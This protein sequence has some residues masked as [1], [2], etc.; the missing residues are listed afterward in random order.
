MNKLH[1]LTGRAGSGKSIKIFNEIAD[2]MDKGGDIWRVLLV[3]DQFT[4]QTERDL[5]NHLHLDGLI[6]VEVLGFGRFIQRLQEEN[7]LSQLKIVDEHGRRMMIKGACAA[8][9]N[10]LQAFAAS[11]Q[12]I[13]FLQ[14]I[15]E[16]IS[17]AKSFGL[18]PNQ[19]LSAAQ[20][21]IIMRGMQDK[22]KDVAL[23][24]QTLEES[25]EALLSQEDLLQKLQ[26][27]L[28]DSKLLAGAEIW[29]DGFNSLS[30]SEAEFVVSV[31]R[32]AERVCCTFTHDESLSRHDR[33]VFR[34]TAQAVDFLNTAAAIQGVSIQKDQLPYLAEKA[35]PSNVSAYI[36]E[37][38][39][40]LPVR[41]VPEGQKG[42]RLVAARNPESEVEDVA[43][44][45]LRRVQNNGI[46]WQDVQVL[47][48]EPERYFP[49]ISRVFPLFH[50]PFFLDTKRTLIHNSAVRFLIAAG[51]LA[52]GRFHV[53]EAM[54]ALKAGFVA[55]P[56]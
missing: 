48:A 49:I 4:L 20:S 51:E 47:C 55:V 7:G 24:W 5:I 6:D 40:D 22:L 38:L 53:Q 30:K 1:I 25:S 37:R 54:V 46:K 32:R 31:A 35:M 41:P 12:K 18:K 9:G 3:P 29:L 17:A 36:E 11:Y 15:E 19:I 16:T 28:D 21:T 52:L 44:N 27:Q 34:P 13:G 8:K 56:E 39:F 50:I 10:Q 45:L 26:A 14:K 42:L 33:Y 23:L 43:I 2:S